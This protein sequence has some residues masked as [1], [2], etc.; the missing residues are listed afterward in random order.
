MGNLKPFRNTESEKISLSEESDKIRGFV[1]ETAEKIGVSERTIEREIQIA[2]NLS[3][4]VKQ[5]IRGTELAD[6]RKD[7][8]AISR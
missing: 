6:R 2:T 1:R 5:M 8:L 3:D 7:L 4:E